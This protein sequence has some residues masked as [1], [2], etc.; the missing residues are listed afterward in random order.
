MPAKKLVQVSIYNREYNIK[1]PQGADVLLKTLAKKL[2]KQ[3]TQLALAAPQFSRDELLVLT[4]LN[5]LQ[6]EDEL[7]QQQQ[8]EQQQLQQ[9]VAMLQQQS[10]SSR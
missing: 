10:P 1:V 3:L 7:L 5:N 4:A 8:S 9:L 6:R 2:D